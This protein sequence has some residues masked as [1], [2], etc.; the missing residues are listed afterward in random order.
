MDSSQEEVTKQI[1][2]ENA[3][4]LVG[5]YKDAVE[6]LLAGNRRL[7]SIRLSQI[8]A[9]EDKSKDQSVT[10]TPEDRKLELLAV[11][12]DFQDKMRRALTKAFDDEE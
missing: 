10:R 1:K 8:Q 4:H 9:I 2:K 11:L 12:E 3:Q 6:S 7:A 5:L